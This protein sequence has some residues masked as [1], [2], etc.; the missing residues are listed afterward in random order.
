M[1]TNTVCP[2]WV[3]SN[4]PHHSSVRTITPG[5]S[6]IQVPSLEFSEE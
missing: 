4:P 3:T 2:S 5:L 1:E 6:I